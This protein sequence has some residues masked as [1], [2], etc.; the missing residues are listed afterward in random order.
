MRRALPF[1]AVA[2]LMLTLS[3]CDN[4]FTRLGWPIPVTKQGKVALTLWQGSW[5]AAFAVGVIVWG[6]IIWVCIFHRKRS[7]DLPPQVRYNLPIEI[8]YTVLP[9]ILI[10]VLFYFTARDENYIDKVT[11][12]PDVVVNVLGYQWSWAFSYP[13]YKV[14]GPAGDV[15]LTG[16]PYPGPL[17]VLVIPRDRT[18]KFTLNSPDVVHSFWVPQFEFKR[19]VIPGRTNTFEITATQTGT[20]LGHCTELCG[21]YHALMLFKVRI[22]TPAQFHAFMHAKQL[23]Q[24]AGGAQ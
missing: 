1:A 11:G 21:V 20:Y 9:F 23:Q 6:A 13:Q 5:I 15:T 4:Q 3:G 2:V 18:V 8:L 14:P 19:D 10:A 24:K 17:P 16:Q 12:H 7:D 22:V